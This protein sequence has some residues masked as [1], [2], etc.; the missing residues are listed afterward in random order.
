MSDLSKARLT[1]D[2]K[3]A[4]KAGDKLRLATI[5]LLLAAVK[6]AEIERGGELKEPE[7]TDLVVKEVKKRREA[8]PMYRDGGRPE[9]ARKEE[10]EA[11]ILQ[12]YLPAQLGEGELEPLIDEAIEATGAEGVRDM[13]KVMGRLAPQTKGR[14][15]GAVVSRL[16]RAKLG[17]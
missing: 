8:I 16:V 7:L 15:D 11:A 10:A 14:A 12:E 2:M 9:L 1:A 5:R 6:N 4:L 13:G 17:G 3:T